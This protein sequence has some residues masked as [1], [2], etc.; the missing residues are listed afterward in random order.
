[1]SRFMYCSS[2]NMQIMKLRT[3]NIENDFSDKH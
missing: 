3:I 1:M 2:I